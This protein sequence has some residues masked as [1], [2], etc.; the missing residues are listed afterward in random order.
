AAAQ[1]IPVF[2]ASGDDG[3]YDCKEDPKPNGKHVFREPGAAGTGTTPPALP[4]RTPSVDY[5]SSDPNVVAV[6]GTN[7]QLNSNGNRS[8]ET[9]WTGAGGGTSDFW[10]RPAWQTGPG[11]PVNDKRNSADVSLVADPWT[12]YAVYFQGNWET[13]GGTSFAAPNWAALWALVDEA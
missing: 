2:A 10:P 12:G 8:S 11:L 1:G 9:A 3:A 6:G 7:L 4:T 13:A 5:P